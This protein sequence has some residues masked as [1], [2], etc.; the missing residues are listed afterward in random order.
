MRR[1]MRSI[2]VVAGC[3]VFIN[4]VAAFGQDW[5]Q[6]RG[7]NRD[8]KAAGFVA[9]QTWPKALT[10]KWKVTVGQGDATPAL[11]GD[12]IYVFARQG[13]D[14]VLLCLDAADGKEI[15]RDKYAAE[16]VTGG[17]PRTRV[18]EAPPLWPMARFSR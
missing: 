16:P 6:W 10:E 13:D 4:A 2:G 15:L 5:P 8:G 14:E 11:V 1:A 17:L 12:R 18:R 9:P 3:A 7:P